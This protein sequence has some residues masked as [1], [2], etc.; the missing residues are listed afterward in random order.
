MTVSRLLRAT[1]HDFSHFSGVILFQVMSD[2]VILA[3]GSANS[4]L[5]KSLNKSL[6]QS[7]MIGLSTSFHFKS[8]QLARASRQ[9]YLFLWQDLYSS[10]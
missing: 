1:T 6:S 2:D 8:S 3:L 7:L 9:L 5:S 4:A 10:G